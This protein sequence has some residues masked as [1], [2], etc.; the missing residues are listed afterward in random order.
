MAVSGLAGRRA[1]RRAEPTRA[2][3]VS[4]PARQPAFRAHRHR[5]RADRR[6]L[7]RCA[8]TYSIIRCRLASSTSLFHHLPFQ[9][10][11]LRRKRT[12]GAQALPV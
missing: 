7:C 5:P 3:R 2:A 1:R 11:F 6:A 8:H 4:R 9:H 10:P 12:R